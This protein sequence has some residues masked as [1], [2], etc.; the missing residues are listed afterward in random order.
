VLVLLLIVL[1]ATD[2]AVAL[3]ILLVLLTTAVHV[4]CALQLYLLVCA[5]LFTAGAK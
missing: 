1:M 4:L 3:P 5:A 2:C